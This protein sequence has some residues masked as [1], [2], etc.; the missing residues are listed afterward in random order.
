M[1]FLDPLAL[2]GG[3]HFYGRI[4]PSVFTLILDFFFFEM[5]T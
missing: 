5:Q 4:L 2:G 3:R 1:T